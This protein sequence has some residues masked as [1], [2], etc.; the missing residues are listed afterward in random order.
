MFRLVFVAL[1][2]GLA[3]CTLWPA[4]DSARE[5]SER[6]GPIQPIDALE[7][8]QEPRRDMPGH[9]DPD[10]LSRDIERLQEARRKYEKERDR[11]ASERRK[12]RTECIEGGDT[13]EITVEDGGGPAVY[14]AP[15]AESSK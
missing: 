13:R 15:P 12:R 1:I 7:Q 5:E 14:C 11:E 8:T 4:D 9:D 10:G 6:K 3:G 2:A